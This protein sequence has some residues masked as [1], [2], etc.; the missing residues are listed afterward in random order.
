MLPTLHA[1]E[2]RF[3]FHDAIRR[4]HRSYVEQNAGCSFQRLARKRRRRGRRLIDAD[5]DPRDEA[6]E[7]RAAHEGRKVEAWILKEAGT[8]FKP[9]VAGPGVQA[10]K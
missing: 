4:R 6:A 5:K 1:Q 3:W 2:I 8:D 9:E 10:V 7:Q